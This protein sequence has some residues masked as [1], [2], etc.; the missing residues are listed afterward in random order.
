VSHREKYYLGRNVSGILGSPASS[1]MAVCQSIEVC[2]TGIHVA[3]VPHKGPH[4]ASL[5]P[6]SNS[7]QPYVDSAK[8][9]WA[10]KEKLMEGISLEM[11]LNEEGDT[12]VP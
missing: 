6:S 8:D 5:L 4:G 9:W 7:L 11:R 2:S 3:G 12:L 10:D 1:L